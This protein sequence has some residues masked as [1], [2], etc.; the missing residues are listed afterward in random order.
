MRRIG[1]S[2]LARPAMASTPALLPR[3]GLRRAH[4]LAGKRLSAKVLAARLSQPGNSFSSTA[5]AT[6]SGLIAWTPTTAKTYGISSIPPAYRDDFGFDEGPRATPCISSN[7]VYTFGAEGAL[8]CLDFN[9]GARKWGLDAKQQ[10]HSGKGFFGVACSP[11]VLGNKM[12]L[13]VGGADGAGIVAFDCADGKVLWKATDDEASYSS[14]VD[15]TLNGKPA[16]LFFTRARLLALDPENGKVQF[17]FPWRARAHASVNAATPLVIGDLIFISASYETGAAL[18]KARASGV[19]KLWSSDDALSNHYATSVSR[20]GCLYGFHGRQESGPSLRCVE[21]KTGKV[22]W[23]KDGFGAGSLLLAG[24]KLVVM[25]EDG[26]L[27]IVSASPQGYRELA[28]AQV[29]PKTVRAYPALANGC[30]YARS[31]DKLVCVDLRP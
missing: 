1:P 18:L 5:L 25:Q 23:S 30:L 29:L 20:D 3:P 4:R 17:G 13:N 31:K 16:V 14:P 21:L 12:M 22:L 6:R 10:F 2:F 15:A 27:L 24:D 11:L 7:Y 19:D 26:Q 9:S 8:T 28:R